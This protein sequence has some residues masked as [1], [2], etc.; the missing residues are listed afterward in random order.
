MDPAS[1]GTPGWIQLAGR[2]CAWIDFAGRGRSIPAGCSVDGWR[3]GRQMFRTSRRGTFVHV[4]I[5]DSC[6]NYLKR[7]ILR[8][9]GSTWNVYPG[10]LY[11]AVLQSDSFFLKM[12][13]QEMA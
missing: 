11:S 5:F 12:D 4:A 8:N 2:P 3:P 13:K 1:W 6:W 7:L 10:T 9:G